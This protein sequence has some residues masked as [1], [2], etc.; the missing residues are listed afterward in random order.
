MKKHTKKL[1]P[2]LII[3]LFLSLNT[4]AQQAVVPSFE[5]VLS[6][7]SVRNATISPDGKQVVYE[8]T[9]TDWEDNRYDTE[10]WLSRDGATPFP[11]TNNAKGNSNNAKWSPDSQWIAYLTKKEDHTQIYAM[12]LAGG[13]SFPVTNCMGDVQDFEWSPD[14]K[15]LLF[16]LAE[17]K[18]KEKKARSSRFGEYAEEDAE[19]LLS[20]LWITAFEPEDW[21][22]QTWPGKIQDSVKLKQKTRI[23]LDSVPYTISRFL[24]SPDGTRVAIQ[25]Q[26]DP[27]INSFFH[28]DIALLD[29]ASG[30]V[31]PL[32]HNPSFDGLIDW[33]P[34]G[35]SILYQTALDDSTSNYYRNGELYITDLTGKKRTRV[36]ANFDEEFSSMNWVENGIYATAYQ[37]TRRMLWRI[38]PALPDEVQAFITSPD[39]INDFSITEDGKHLA[40]IGSSPDQLDEIYVKAAGQPEIQITHNTNQISGW[41]VADGDVIQWASKDGAQIEGVLMKP[42]DYNP[43]KKY[44]LLVVIHGGPTGISLPAPLTSYVYP[45]TQWLAKGALVLMPNYRGSA[46]YGEGFRSLNVRNLGVGDAWD[47]LSGVDYLIERGMVDPDSMGC[48]GWSQGGYISAFLTTNTDRFKAISVGAG[49]SDW[50]T[51]YVNTDIHPFTRQ[52]LKSTPWSDPGIYALTSPITT[53]NQAKTPTLI[54][55]GEFDRRVPIANGYELYQGLQDVGVPVKMMVYKGF[56]HGITKPK[57]RLAATWHNWQW[58][59]KYIWGE[60]LSMPEK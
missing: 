37:K 11:L 58:F 17:D 10:L 46:G 38:D 15:K 19:F 4:N 50:M 2:Y 8:V 1:F 7:Q 16:L 33:S 47:V 13:E 26:P 41:K 43:A 32:I 39:R 20:R 44:P 12:R 60:E 48:M 45:I 42:A 27:M 40:Y 36:A 5:A 9:S 14:G 31:T 35:Q 54:Q 25:H 28:S 6:L 34:D 21:E 30:I 18:E 51:Y 3:L 53:I 52:Y 22:T 59:G 24:W 49:I 56:G 23:L 57:E 29:P 55:H